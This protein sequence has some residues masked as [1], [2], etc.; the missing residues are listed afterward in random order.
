MKRIILAG[1]TMA[2]FLALSLNAGAQAES[3]SARGSS[4]PEP[5]L[6]NVDWLSEHLSDPS[7]VILQIGQRSDYEAGHIPG[8]QWLDNHNISTPYGQGLTL[9]LPPMA[10][11][12]ETF[13]AL[14]V[15]DSSRIVLCFGTNWVTGTA[16]VFLTLDT[17]GLGGRSSILDGGLPAWRAAGKPVTAEVKPPAR[18]KITPH[19]RSD[20]VVDADWVSAHLNAPNTIILDA[21]THGYYTGA[22]NAGT[23]RQGHIPGAG[24]LPFTSVVDDSN[25]LKDPDALRELLR[26][27][28]VKPGELVVSYCHIGQQASLIF[29]VAKYLGYDARMYDGSWEDWSARKQLPIVQGEAP[30]KP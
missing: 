3:P 18:G 7:V 5:M 11:L 10:Q 4:G 8:A 14:G 6:V 12:V 28:G 20:V 13:E 29:F 16:R 2:I 22:D 15:S 23:P 24:N 19:P 1:I 21:R 27:A 26:S 9:E 30:G 17:M 25:K